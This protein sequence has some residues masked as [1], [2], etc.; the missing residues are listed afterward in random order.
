M[1]QASWPSNHH[2]EPSKLT[3]V[4]CWSINVLVPVHFRKPYQNPDSWGHGFHPPP[5]G[6][7]HK[8]PDTSSGGSTSGRRRS[9]GKAFWSAGRIPGWRKTTPRWGMRHGSARTCRWCPRRRPDTAA[10]E[11]RFLG[12]TLYCEYLNQCFGLGS[13]TRAYCFVF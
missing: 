7:R 12:L 13:T 5:S 4:N 8:D 3:L 9:S 6:W 2:L 10:N 11:N 1:N